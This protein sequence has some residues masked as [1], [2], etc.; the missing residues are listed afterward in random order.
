[1]E[2]PQL[3]L[4]LIWVTVIKAHELA[5]CLQRKS[6][7]R[8]RVLI[9]V[10]VIWEHDSLH[11]PSFYLFCSRSNSHQYAFRSFPIFWNKV[12]RDGDGERSNEQFQ[13]EFLLNNN[14]QQ[15]LGQYICSILK[16]L[17]W[18][19]IQLYNDVIALDHFSL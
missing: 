7:Y 2:Q 10:G 16:Q 9:S 1:M 12:F 18:P 14:V 17:T 6:Q 15:P 3:Q 19:L 8:V 5:Y 11:C 13:S 4:G